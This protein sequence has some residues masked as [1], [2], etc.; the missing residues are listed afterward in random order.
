VSSPSALVDAAR[1][2]PSPSSTA[3][4][5]VA[6]LPG[7]V[8]EA[9][10]TSYRMEYVSPR[11][12]DL[13]GL[14]PD[15]WTSVPGFWEAHLHPHD[16]E[17][18]IA[19]V[20]R[21]LADLS[22][23]TCE[24]RFR[25]ADGEYRHVRDVL[26][27]VE[28]PDGH[29]RIV[30]FMVEVT[31]EASIE[32]QRRLL[33][34]AVREARESIAITDAAGLV[35]YVNPAFERAMGYT[36]QEA[37]GRP[38]QEIMGLGS[39]PTG[40]LMRQILDSGHPWTGD[41]RGHR[42]DGTAFIEEASVNAVLDDGG[43]PASWVAISRDVTA[44]RAESESKAR[45]ATIVESAADAGYC[46]AL[47]GTYLA[48]N[49]AAT[50]I[51]GWT[52]EEVLGRTAFELTAPDEHASI[53]EWIRRVGAGETIGPIDAAH[54]GR[55]GR[56]LTLSVIAAPVRDAN[57]TITGIATIARDVAHERRLDSERHALEAQ[58][59][60]ARKLEAIGRLAGGIAH[61]FNN[62]LTAISGYA[63]LVAAEL[64]GTALEDQRQVLHAAERAAEL[65]QRLL[66]FSRPAPLNPRAI[67]VDPVLQD[68]Y[69]MLRRLV[70]ERIE[71]E[72]HAGDGCAV[73]AD[74]VELEQLLLN[75]VLNAADAISGTGRIEVSTRHAATGPVSA[76]PGPRAWVV[77]RVADSGVGMDEATQ[78]RIFEPFFTTKAVGVGTGLGL[79]TV[80]AI[81]HRAGGQ[82]EVESSPGRGTAFDV[83]LPVAEA[84]ATVPVAAV[85]ADA[86]GHERILVVDDSPEVGTL[87]ARVL[88]RAGYTVTLESS[89]LAVLERGAGDID[90][91]VSDVVMPGVSGPEMVV[92]LGA[93][94]PVVFVSGYAGTHLPPDIILGPRRAFVAKPFDARELLQTL[95]A[96]LDG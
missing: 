39:L 18:A 33:A 65:T 94:L 26:R 42:R 60:Q 86:D 49:D 24:Y 34:A 83:F 28:H 55:D 84:P 92:R 20:D 57:G 78:A 87:A 74:P 77:L 9:D 21:A 19:A 64:T 63:S 2:R 75:L 50:R 3:D 52:H 13:L 96:V 29:R 67:A 1:G 6:T 72:L 27:V 95:R 25:A 73:I 37:A 58:L 12:W 68:A 5:L 15:E 7:I 76:E 81:V 8:W 30:G 44:E 71:I 17:R 35:V 31:D 53:A 14:D 90:A 61:D 47:D 11:A 54:R 36:A 22:S 40:E 89:P 79:A 23:I 93:D 82:I 59:Q 62:M 46:N 4:D 85:A 51:Y 32:S 66:A 88:R 56:R 43:R 91:I 16:R 48:W 38:A 10:G 41:L 69:R 45:L 70:P 80:H